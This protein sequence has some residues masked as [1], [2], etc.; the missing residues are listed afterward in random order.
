MHEWWG[1]NSNKHYVLLSLRI[2][3]HVIYVHYTS[4]H[5]Y[6]VQNHICCPEKCYILHC[7]AT[8]GLLP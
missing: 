8:A 3:V 5:I 4:G 6:A 1:V 7:W 2:A